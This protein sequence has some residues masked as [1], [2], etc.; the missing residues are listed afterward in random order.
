[1]KIH[2]IGI[3]GIGISAIARMY[4]AEGNEISG[5]DKSE[6]TITKELAKA[7]AKIFYNH[8]AK[9]IP[10]DCDL[11]IYTIAVDAT[12]QEFAEAKQREIKLLSYPQVLGE[13]TTKKKTIA[14]SGT[15]GKTT[16]TAMI[17]QIFL[18]AGLDPTVIV[19][20]LMKTYPICNDISDMSG[21]NFIAGRGEYLIVEACEYRRSFL[22]LSPRLV[23]IT[24]IDN[25]HL[26]Y[27][28]DLA[29]IQSAFA[30]FIAKLPTDGI[31]VCDSNDERLKPILEQL[32]LKNPRC[33]VVDYT[34][35]D[36]AGTQL[37]IPGAHNVKNAQAAM[38]VA[39][40][41]GISEK[42]ARQALA[43][44]TGTW[45]RFE[46]KGKTKAGAIVYDD[47]A[48]HPSEIKA[49]L[50]G[51]RE[52]FPNHQII[53]IFQPHLYSRTRLL[54]NDFGTSFHDAAEVILLPIYA[55][56][57]AF[58]PIISSEI[59]A[60]KINKQG[61]SAHFVADFPAAKDYLDFLTANSYKLK[62]TL[63]ITIGAG[64]V[65]QIAEKL[66]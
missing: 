63:I 15:H 24:N 32:K 49:M 38:A 20:S 34:K 7:G 52:A 59:L 9:N 8:D 43:D 46:F 19:G 36:L 41:A 29:D 3:G 26:D 39:L 51:A 6:S 11:V 55:A 25:D 2:F 4:L 37:K 14:V 54:L 13:L 53:A 47:Y 58:D 48:H 42:V 21:T 45:R 44:F 30:E 50:A 40:A 16:T 33:R 35:K 28:K 64:D 60:E 66:I 23:V 1:M 31:L 57:E 18:A 56:R 27:Y 61:V 17:A 10:D 65:Y 22:N 5:S 12:N 62:A